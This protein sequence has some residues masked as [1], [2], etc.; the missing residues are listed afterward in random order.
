MAKGALALRLFI[1]SCCGSSSLL[2]DHR[3]LGTQDGLSAFQPGGLFASAFFM[4]LGPDRW[5]WH[6][7]SQSFL[8]KYTQHVLQ[9]NVTTYQALQTLKSP[10]HESEGS[11]I[12]DGNFI[13]SKIRGGTEI[14]TKGGGYCP[15]AV[16][17]TSYH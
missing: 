14:F 13:Q 10:S 2:G 1:V 7:K 4:A 17:N 9:G 5:K 15:A 11:K 3:A 6:Y 8:L 16:L 12:L